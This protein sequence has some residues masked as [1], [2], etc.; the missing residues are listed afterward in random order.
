MKKVVC[1]HLL[2][3]Y[4]GSPLVLSQSIKGLIENGYAVDVYTNKHSEG[5]LTNLSGVNYFYFNYS[6]G[7]SKVQTLFYFV[8]SQLFLFMRLLK[9]RKQDVTIYVNTML[10]FGAA[11]A[12][13]FMHKKVIYHMHETSV[14]PAFLKS[15]LLKVVRFTASDLIYVSTYLRTTEAIKGVKSYTVYNALSE[16]FTMQAALSTR[17]N[18]SFKNV[19][20]LCSLKK[21]KGVDVYIQLARLLPSYSFTLVLNSSTEDVKEYLKDKAISSNLIIHSAQKNVHPFFKDADLVLNLSLTDEWIETFGMTVLEAMSYGLPVIVP[22]I[23]GI[24]ELVTDEFNGFKIDSKNVDFISN[25]IDRIFTNKSFYNYLSFNAR[26]R[27]GD[28]TNTNFV[29]AVIEVVES[30]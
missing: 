12:G 15:F 24:A 19:L 21:Y 9:Y 14:K 17:L 10:P 4:S 7:K 16:D 26:K 5:F 1:V 20:M 2:N 11:L 30:N 22:P 25:Q 29:K 3:D 27:S 6:W 28:F 18:R 8:F 13:R 23:G